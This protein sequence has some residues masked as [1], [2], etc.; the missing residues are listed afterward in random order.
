[1]YSAT[2]LVT[3]RRGLLIMRRPPGAVEMPVFTS[4]RSSWLT[5]MLG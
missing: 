5:L 1:V 4:R 2:R 3:D